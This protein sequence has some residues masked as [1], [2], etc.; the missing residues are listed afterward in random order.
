MQH[1]E[2]ENPGTL[3]QLEAQVVGNA[4]GEREG[5][6]AT[7]IALVFQA[8]QREV[9]EPVLHPFGQG[10]REDAG[11]DRHLHVAHGHQLVVG[12]DEVEVRAISRKLLAVVLPDVHAVLDVADLLQSR[13][14]RRSRNLGLQQVGDEVVVARATEVDVATAVAD[15]LD[16]V[17][18]H[19]D[20]FRRIP[21]DVVARLPA[22]RLRDDDHRP[23]ARRMLAHVGEQLGLDAPAD[24]HHGVFDHGL[25]EVNLDAAHHRVFRRFAHLEG[26]QSV[27]TPSFVRLH[28]E[29]QLLA[30]RQRE[31]A[32]VGVDEDVL[33]GSTRGRL[34]TVRGFDGRPR[35]EP[36]VAAA[37]HLV[38]NAVET[39]DSLLRI[40]QQ[41]VDF[42]KEL[43]FPP[44]H[45]RAR[46]G[47]ADS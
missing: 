1:A 24:G 12:A 16:A 39:H 19:D 22:N 44:E 8:R 10:L 4:D 20:H 40:E 26:A 18:G 38:H 14:E 35:D 37:V 23:G 9:G 25:V 31:G 2:D 46:L 28:L 11:R 3:H 41:D 5:Q 13:P 36:E 17:H 21:V 43:L 32:I 47:R 42:W 6:L 34:R 30:D 27:A 15:A 7:R 29:G 45:L 33:A